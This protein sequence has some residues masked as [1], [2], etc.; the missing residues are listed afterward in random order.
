ME[1][2]QS[3]RKMVLGKPNS[4][5]QKN[6]TR[7]ILHDTWKLTKNES[8]ALK[9]KT[10]NHK[11]LR[12]KHRQWVPWHLSWQWAP[13]HLSWQWVFEFGIKRSPGGTSSKELACQ[14]RGH[15]R[16]GF[17]P[18]VREIPWRKTRQPTPVFLPRESSQ[19]G[20][21]GGL[22][23]IG[24]ERV[25]YEWSD[26]AHI[27]SKGNNKNKQV[28][29]NQTKKFLHRK[30]SI[31][32]KGSLPNQKKNSRES[33]IYIWWEANIQNVSWTC[34]TQNNNK[35]TKQPDWKTGRGSE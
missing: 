22:Q 15:K 11:T 28:E 20:E 29:L 32:W 33:Y 13:W 14:C 8:K 4:H 31:K 21:A 25:G 2:G 19:T 26:L 16:H 23:F 7:P 34:K 18:W 35:N 10:W 3:L 9:C 1:K 30:K 5:M 24:S 17:D 6:K 27:E 12:R